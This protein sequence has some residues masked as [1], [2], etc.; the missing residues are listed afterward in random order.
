MSESTSFELGSVDRPTRFQVN[1]VNHRKN[2]K[3]NGKDD[4][5]HEVYRRLTNIDGEPV[6]D[7]QF[8]EDAS[9]MP[10]QP[11]TQRIQSIKSSF[12]DKDKPSRFKDLQTTRFQVDPRNEDSD[13]SNE[14][15]ED[16]ELLENEYDTKYGKSFRHFTR[17]ALP[18]LDNYRNIMSIQ[19]AYRPTLDELHNATLTGKMSHSLNR[20]Q[21]PETAI[22][23]GM[24]K[25][26]WIKGVLIRC[27]LNIWGV[28]L[29]LR[30]SWVV[31]QAGIVEGFLLILT[32][33]AVTTITALSMSAISTNGV[34]KGGGTYY[35]ISR[36]LGPEFG[37]SIGLIF[38]LANAVAC[39][40]YVVGFC[41]SMMDLLRSFGAQIVDGGV[42]DVRIV[43]SITILIL[44]VIVVVGMEWEAKAQIGLLIILLIA[45]AD[46]MIGTLIGPKSDEEKAKGFLGY[47]STLFQQNLFA[48]YRKEKN[49]QHDFF[50]VFAIF[51]P[52]ATGIL[53][54]AN[55]SGDLKDP[56]KSIPKGTILAIIIT[57]ATYLVM[58]LMVG[59]TVA[60]DAT[61]N[62]TDTVNG[63][64][65]FL[66]CI[67]G[68]C[69]YGLENSFQVIELVSGFGP[70]IYAGCFAATLSS[71]LAS[72][73]SAPKVFQAL[74][75]DE[76]YPKIVWFAKG[77]GKN[78][79]P[80]RGY[81]LTFF[82]AI[83][84]ILIGELNLIAPLISNFFLAAYMLI[85]FST[86]HASL[87]QP[88]GWR[89]TFKY[90]NMWLSLIGAVLCVAVMFLISWWTAL[91]TFVAV[92]AL[93]LIVSY[94]KPDVNWGST[95][96]A[97]TYKNALISVQQ[98]NNVEE[99]V[100]NYRPQILVLSGLPNT[101]PVLVDFAYMLTK[102]LSLLVCG[103]V[104]R[105]SSSQRYRNY[106]QERAS[107]WFRKHR[108]KGFYS[109]VDG[110]DF[111]AGSKALMQASGIGKL[112]PN[113]LLLGYKTD[114]QTCERKDLNL[115][116]NIMHKALDM[117]L[118]VA[119]LRVSNGLDCSQILGD[120][121]N[122]QR[123]IM[124][125]PRTLQPN[126]S[127]TD[128]N[129]VDKSAH[130][131]LGGS[132]DSLSRNVSQGQDGQTQ[133]PNENG[134][135]LIKMFKIPL[136]RITFHD[137]ASST[138]DL[139]F[140]VNTHTK[141]QDIT[142][143]PDPADPKGPLILTNSLRKS[144]KTHD[145]PASLYKGPGGVELP[146]EVLN[147]LTQ[148]TRKRS[149]AVIDVWWLYDDGGLT[150]LLPYIISTRKQWQSCKLRV[151]ALA[152]KKA[153]ME[154][155]QRS[156]AS[157][158]SKFR[159]DYSDLQLIPDITKKPQESSTQFFNELIKDFVVSENNV[160][161][162]TPVNEDEALT[163]EDDLLNVQDKT[164]RYLRLREYL[165]EKS[166][167]S[168]LVVMTLPM[169]RKNI[170]SAPLYMAWL[171]S[172]SRGMPPFLFVRGNQTSVLTFYS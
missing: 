112:K 134:L 103:H 50:S 32:T 115:Y 158:L 60:R 150:L 36:S 44:L 167:K 118:S 154:F 82:I 138:S 67:P 30:L 37:G 61:G 43:G 27:L 157:L 87:A 42:Q 18:R 47:N 41:E 172:L 86:F 107:S 77:F 14:S 111:E 130:N 94:R 17:E 131:G 114:W 16:R 137:E 13:D 129:A 64:Y 101:R 147:D 66:D 89:P 81:V 113:I 91:I 15:N 121:S 8:N 45:I 3:D 51:F 84:F 170:V 2:D 39:A 68:N 12:R 6:E 155:E 40:M 19:A 95:T 5:P 160:N 149:H 159:I 98:L 11:R 139:S 4:V 93:Y 122:T 108:V 38:S 125:V 136:I 20:N 135:K 1:P 72:L 57:T 62:V 31:G 110:E 80:V 26:G 128:L 29:F 153:E 145:D 21:D 166:V 143:L 162:T 132:M 109:L 83:G 97:Q 169:P 120:E 104:L 10:Q 116:F 69:S 65:A 35:M 92:L 22:L 168:D 124:E 119:I 53:A 63:S 76:L 73:V 156:M 148:F 100:K 28:M 74:C 88:V 164:N 133:D 24:L 144:K 7:D 78:N 46:F 85:N 171:E 71:A 33:T 126:E 52:A 123:N 48:D 151:Y 146:K 23:N 70:L 105:G 55:I 75:K 56:Q 117:Y 106:L 79:E 127:S 102:N 99:H 9:Q 58:V 25:F 96:Q 34:I 49:I 54:G 163:T 142:G 152:N 161:I 59:A 165:L 90:Y 140:T 141:T